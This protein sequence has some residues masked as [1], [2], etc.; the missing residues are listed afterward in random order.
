MLRVGAFNIAHGRGGE[1]G[2]SN[3]ASN[4]MQ[5]LRAHMTEIAAQIRDADLDV[6]VLNEVDFD[7]TWSRR[8]D[9]ASLIAEKAGFPFCVEQRNMD[10]SVPLRTYRFGNAILSKLPVRSAQVIRFPP[11]S[12]RETL[13]AGNHDGLNVVL[14][15]ESGD[16]RV[17][18]VHLEFRDEDTRVAASRVIQGLVS[19]D[20]GIP[21]I[22]MGDYNSAP[23]GYAGHRFSSENENAV[24]VL[25][26]A[27]WIQGAADPET[28]MTFPSVKPD[29][30]IDW[31]LASPGLR[32]GWQTVVRS[33][34]SDHLMVVTEL[35]WRAGGGEQ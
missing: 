8:I 19:A 26:N 27:G 9:Q 32:L 6:L 17:V 33:R 3:W 15:T 31:I 35:A 5:S 21:C 18:A 30:A 25:L 7:A 10:V 14:E 23:T 29:R 2:A 24:D 11:L 13:L 16:L 20:K 1:L 34:L 22:A 28:Y 4:S 12:R